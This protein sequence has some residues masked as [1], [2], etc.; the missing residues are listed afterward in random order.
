MKETID[1]HKEILEGIQEYLQSF[2]SWIET[3]KHQYG[4]NEFWIQNLKSRYDQERKDYA[5]YRHQYDC[6]IRAKKTAFDRDKYLVV[7]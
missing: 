3:I 5:F 2:G 7:K 4:Q 6:A 1:K